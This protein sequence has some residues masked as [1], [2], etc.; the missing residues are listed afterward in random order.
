MTPEI[1]RQQYP[2]GSLISELVGIDHGQYIVRVLVEVE[3]V[4]LASGLSAAVTVEQ[5]EDQARLRAL[6]LLA[7]QAE[8]AAKPKAATPAKTRTSPP[9]QVELPATS[10]TIPGIQPAPVAVP[11][12]PS[13]P[14]EASLNLDLPFS[15]PPAQAST[16]AKPQATMAQVSEDE[17]PLD[18]SDIIARSD[19]ELKRL[20]WSSEQGRNYLLETYGKRSRQLLSDDELLEF[21]KYLEA[22]PTPH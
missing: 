2:Q 22:T 13:T 7:A 3:G 6:S 21:L 15:E 9:P 8:P 12:T 17:T 5:A 14:T 20:G 19:V 11:T 10:P 1:F 16:A 4:T 18:F